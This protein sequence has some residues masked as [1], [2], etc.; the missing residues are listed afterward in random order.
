M[1]DRRLLLKSLFLIPLFSSSSVKASKNKFDFN[2]CPKT[3]DELNSW[4]SQYTLNG[5][6]YKKPYIESDVGRLTFIQY[7][8]GVSDSEK[9]RKKLIRLIWITIRSKIEDS[10]NEIP[11]IYWRKKPSIKD[12]EVDRYVFGEKVKNPIEISTRFCLYPCDLGG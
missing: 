8:M 9:N 3:L 12:S 7:K 10:G 4:V 11:T 2:Y 5:G 1:L 6:E